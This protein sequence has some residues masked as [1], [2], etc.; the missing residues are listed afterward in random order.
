MIVQEARKFSPPIQIIVRGWRGE[1]VPMLLYSL[2]NGGKVAIVGGIEGRQ[3]IGLP[4]GDC[5]PY[6]PEVLE[7]LRVAHGCNDSS[8]LSH[9]YEAWRNKNIEFPV[10]SAIDSTHGQ[11]HVAHPERP[12]DCSE[13]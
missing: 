10:D 9:I 2:E 8:G 5:F 11:A 12:E 4:I 1:P 6:D 7:R 3:T 13:Q